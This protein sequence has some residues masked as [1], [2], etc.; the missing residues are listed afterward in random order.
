MKYTLYFLTIGA[1]QQAF[2]K[3]HSGY[4]PLATWLARGVI[5]VQVIIAVSV[6]G[7]VL[8]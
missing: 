7:I 3:N 2:S 5:V 1:W 8:H 6:L 4:E